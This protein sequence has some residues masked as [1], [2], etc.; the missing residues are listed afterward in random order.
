MHV[1]PDIARLSKLGVH[2]PGV[3][4]YQTPENVRAFAMAQDAQPTIVTTANSG[5]PSFLNTYVDPQLIDV[6]FAPNKAVEIVGTEVQKGNWAT[7]TAVFIQTENY[8]EVST[9]GDFNANGVVGINPTFPQ[10]QQYV[11]QTNVVY[12]DREADMYGE[13]RI[14]LANEKRKSATIVLN[15]FQNT[16]YFLGVSNLQNYGLLND[17]SLTANLTPSAGTWTAATSGTTVY[18]DILAMFSQ[19]QTQTQGLVEMEDEMTLAIPPVVAPA[20]LKIMT[21][22]STGIAGNV[23][24][25]LAEAFPKLTI[26]TA[27][28]YNSTGSGNVAQLIAKNLEGLPTAVC[29]Y[30]EKLRAHR[31]EQYTSGFRQKMSQGTWGTIIFRPLAIVGMIGV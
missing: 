4:D 29:A 2:L 11:Y 24:A 1:N 10:R 27:V 25:Q 30:S 6:L 22:G 13:A 21:I 18:T 9:Y 31:V 28:Q 16:S 15:K 26:K 3:V 20:L 14:N 8:G 23:R 7:P 17:P 19:M 12:G 5:I